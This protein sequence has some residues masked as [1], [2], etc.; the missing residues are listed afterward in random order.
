MDL[1]YSVLLLVATYLWKLPTVQSLSSHWL[2]PSPLLVFHHDIGLIRLASQLR[3]SGNP[4]IGCMLSACAPRVGRPAMVW[5]LPKM[6][7]ARVWE[8]FL[9]FAPLSI[10]LRDGNSVLLRP[11]WVS[12][13][14]NFLR[15][16]DPR[17]GLN[18]WVCSV[19]SRRSVLL[20]AWC[21]AS[22]GAVQDNCQH[23]TG[24]DWA[25][26]DPGTNGIG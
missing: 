10:P 9:A 22:S 13:Y 21:I 14:G 6:D 23:W 1:H 19:C 18:Q 11:V 2:E 17:V 5:T 20:R 8:V 25:V 12:I 24:L 15:I 26:F 3:L 16:P 7:R 4:F